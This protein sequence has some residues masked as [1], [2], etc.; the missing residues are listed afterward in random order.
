MRATSTVQQILLTQFEK[1]LYC[2]LLPLA[3]DF[4]VNSS[5]K[6]A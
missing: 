2:I 4:R 1:W 5:G 6:R 3:D